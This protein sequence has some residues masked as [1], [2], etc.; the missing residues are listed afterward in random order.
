MTL[1]TFKPL[2]YNQNIRKTEKQTKNMNGQLTAMKERK[3]I[4]LYVQ[5]NY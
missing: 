1:R 2:F 3:E 5:E 4:Q